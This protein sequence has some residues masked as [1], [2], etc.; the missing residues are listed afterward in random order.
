MQKR[1]SGSRNQS[2]VFRDFSRTD[3]NPECGQHPKECQGS[4]EHACK[5]SSHTHRRIKRAVESS[6]FIHTEDVNTTAF[7]KMTL[8][9]AV[10]I[11][12]LRSSTV[13]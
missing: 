7:E 10:G 4:K 13:S 12:Q 3:V 5:I 1:R 9:T 11:A 6:K 8:P 2:A